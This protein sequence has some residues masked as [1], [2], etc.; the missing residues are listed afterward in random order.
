M[1]SKPNVSSKL[2]LLFKEIN[3]I[4]NHKLYLEKCYEK[5]E[6][7]LK[8]NEYNF[9]L[10]INRMINIEESINTN[11]DTKYTTS[12]IDIEEKY[13]ELLIKITDIEKLINSN[14]TNNNEENKKMEKIIIKHNLLVKKIIG[15]QKKYIM[16]KDDMINKFILTNN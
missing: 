2:E 6:E 7:K 1:S 5:L 9:K 8:E 4:N 13:N 3:N 16:F 14:N 12:I 10:I 15:Y 11:T